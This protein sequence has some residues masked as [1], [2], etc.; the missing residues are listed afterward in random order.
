MVH[1]F[2]T[3]CGF[4]WAQRTGFGGRAAVDE[5]RFGRSTEWVGMRVE[6]QGA[7]WPDADSGRG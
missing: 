1:I 7:C 5:G 2:M 6:D 3:E 4:R